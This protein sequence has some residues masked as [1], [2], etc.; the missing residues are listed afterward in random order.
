MNNMEKNGP[1]PFFKG[2]LVPTLIV[3]AVILVVF[4]STILA[5]KLFFG[6]KD[7]VP[8][9]F[10]FPY[11]GVKIVEDFPSNGPVEPGTEMRKKVY[12]S[13]T[14]NADVFLRFNYTES[15]VDKDGNVLS[16]TFDH[17]DNSSTP[18]IQVMK[19]NWATGFTG[20]NDAGMPC[21]QNLGDGYYYYSEI[22]SGGQVTE[23]V[24]N[25]VTLHK[26]APD[27]Y[28]KANYILDFNVEVVVCNGNSKDGA[29]VRAFWGK[30]PDVMHKNM[31]IWSD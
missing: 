25:S 14:G 9:Y 28:S 11:T 15:W 13:N 26:D 6:N 16:N 8:N 7:N 17:D 5:T 29:K 22:L 3:L 27:S 18:E 24:L 20:Y 2:K 4:L 31:V 30:Y 10:P 12:F 19:K 23:P 21:W 1:N